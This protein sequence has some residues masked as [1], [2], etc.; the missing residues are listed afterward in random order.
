MV[1]RD[2]EVIFWRVI[3]DH[4]HEMVAKGKCHHEYE[5]MYIEYPDGSIEYINIPPLKKSTWN[6]S[7][8]PD[9]LLPT[10]QEALY[11]VNYKTLV[12]IHNYYKLSAV[13]LC[14]PSPYI[15]TQFEYYVKE[16]KTH[17]D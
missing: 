8:L 12:N 6:W 13:T 17:D 11:N 15:L 14:C 16:F 7:N 4:T 3:D 1:C 2:Q 9:D 5:G 10:I